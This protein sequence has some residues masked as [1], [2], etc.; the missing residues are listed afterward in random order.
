MEIKNLII[1]LII[2]CLTIPI[3]LALEP[4]EDNIIH[5]YTFDTDGTDYYGIDDMELLNG[6]SVTGG[7]N[8]IL[9]ETLTLDGVDDLANIT[10]SARLD[11][12]SNQMTITAWVNH[13]TE[14]Q[15]TIVSKW[16]DGTTAAWHF[17]IK[18]D[19][20]L[21]FEHKIGGSYGTL[22]TS[23]DDVDD[24]GGWYFV[25][26]TWNS[27]APGEELKLY[28]NGVLIANKTLSGALNTNAGDVRIGKKVHSGGDYELFD[29]YIDEVG[30]WERAL[31]AEEIVD[32]YNS[33]TGKHPYDVDETTLNNSI[34]L[35]YPYDID[36]REQ[37]NLTEN[38]T[39]SNLVRLG[40]AKLGASYNGAL[41]TSENAAM[42]KTSTALDTTD[43]KLSVGFW[44][45]HDA[46]EESMGIITITNT[47]NTDLFSFY[48]KND[49][50]VYRFDTNDGVDQDN[51][52][53][54]EAE[55]DL[56]VWNYILLEYDGSSKRIYINETLVANST[57]SPDFTSDNFNIY[58]FN[59]G[60][61]AN[62][63]DTFNGSIDEVMIANTNMSGFLSELYNNGSGYNPFGTT[64]SNVSFILTSGGVAL[65]DFNITINGT[66]YT[67]NDGEAETGIA[68]FSGEYNITFMATGFTTAEYEN[69]ELEDNPLT[70]T[71][72]IT[73][74]TVNISWD[75]TTDMNVNDTITVSC[76]Y[77]DPYGLDRNMSYYF[78]N[79]QDDKT[80]YGIGN[81]TYLINNSDF[82]DNINAF[83][84][85]ETLYGNDTTENESTGHDN[86]DM[87][88]NFL[89]TGYLD[90]HIT[91]A[92]ST[93]LN[94]GEYETGSPY[95][96]YAS[97]FINRT[98]K[99]YAEQIMINETSS[100]Y[101]PQTFSRT[102]NEYN[103]TYAF[104]LEPNKLSLSFYMDGVAELVDGYIVDSEP[105]R[106]DFTDT[107]FLI[108]QQNLSEGY[109]Y[110]KIN[111]NVTEAFNQ[112]YEYENEYN[113]YITEDIEILEN[114]T[115]HGYIRVVDQQ[116]RPIE[117]AVVR[118]IMT[119]PGES[120]FYNGTLIG[121]RLTDSEGKTDFYGDHGTNLRITILKDN[122][123]IKS[124]VITLN[125]FIGDDVYTINNRKIFTIQ[126]NITLTNNKVALIYNKYWYNTENNIPIIIYA[127]D[128]ELIEIQTQYRIDN[129]Q[130]TEITLS[131]TGTATTGFYNYNLRPNYELD[132]N[133]TYNYLY[134]YSDNELVINA[135]IE[136]I[137][138]ENELFSTSDINATSAML[139][140]GIII[141]TS[142]IGGIFTS[143]TVSLV[144]FFTLTAIAAFLNPAFYWILG[145]GF[146]TMLLWMLNK[147]IS[148]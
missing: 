61:A 7:S 59:D 3:G 18:S 99:T 17:Y 42:Y 31:S 32:L 16:Y 4:V 30:L 21:G 146:V 24:A 14:A 100:L 39:N 139:G 118:L 133:T 41:A 136:T 1:I 116:N 119:R 124:E 108:I 109:V 125:E 142:V 56:G 80:T 35:Y 122:Y 15:Q 90:Q 43:D 115:W 87:L 144:T 36:G 37:I 55:I 134:V 123:G 48:Y 38:Q 113:T 110:V 85:L 106:R 120:E 101:V 138:I 140:M 44:M 47:T 128:S 117:G 33:G 67:T 111:D 29:G 57:T 64:E 137:E 12:M 132:D 28:I 91:T 82:Q 53:L 69:Q 73:P 127:P 93:F 88:Y 103:A 97:N 5:Y 22:E 112:Y 9:G 50:S 130:T 114:G 58:V 68:M 84:V 62:T 121:Q 40:Y 143:A 10:D 107:S 92:T 45:K 20:A 66:T 65:D 11:N 126:N 74:L 77:T 141:G 102:L 25:T 81:R 148:G 72:N 13:D 34:S 129:N 76:N 49:T 79:T 86:I 83:C 51:L 95:Y 89:V 135:T 23:A 60:T 8:G 96:I 105:K 63:F 2:A 19:D 46:R 131:E 52:D 147:V 26:A 94:S 54:P 98:S 145:I 70:Y 27:S 6:A 104:E 75:Y 71:I 78:V